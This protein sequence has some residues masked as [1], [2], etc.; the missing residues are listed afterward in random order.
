MI[1]QAVNADFIIARLGSIET[2]LDEV[3]DDTLEDLGR[4]LTRVHA[5]ISQTVRL[6]LAKEADHD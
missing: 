5:A 4:A 1:D 2:H 6:R 3:D